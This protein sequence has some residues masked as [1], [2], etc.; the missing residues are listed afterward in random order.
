[1]PKSYPKRQISTSDGKTKRAAF[2]GDYIHAKEWFNGNHYLKTG[3]RINYSIRDLALSIFEWHNETLNIWTHLFGTLVCLYFLFW[4]SPIILEID[5][6]VKEYTSRFE[7][8]SFEL[9]YLEMIETELKPFKTSFEL[10]HPIKSL[11]TRSNVSELEMFSNSLKKSIIAASSFKRPN[12]DYGEHL[13]VSL[14]TVGKF[15]YENRKMFKN[16]PNPSKLDQI[17]QIVFILI[18]VNSLIL[19]IGISKD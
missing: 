3:Y 16:G 15:V 8:K 9:K 5:Q 10:M 14:R 13:F 12:N 4:L 1:M 2:I 11:S 7:S 17:I 6:R 18:I 19:F